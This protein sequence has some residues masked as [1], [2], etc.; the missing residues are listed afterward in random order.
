MAIT[1]SEACNKPWNI[2]E[3]PCVEK[4]LDADGNIVQTKRSGR[5][6]AT[7]HNVALNY[8]QS[9]GSN[10]EQIQQDGNFGSAR[11]VINGNP[12]G[13]TFMVKWA[14]PQGSDRAVLSDVNQGGTTNVW[15]NIFRVYPTYVALHP[16]RA[17][18]GQ[19]PMAIADSEAC[20]KPW[21]IL[22]M[23]CVEKDLDADGNQI[24]TK[25]SGRLSAT[26]HNVALNYNQSYGSNGEQIQQDGDFGSVRIVIN[27]TPNGGTPFMV[28]WADPQGSD[29]AVLSDVN[30]GGTTNVWK[31]VF[32]VFSTYVEAPYST[33]SEID[34]APGKALVTKDWV[35]ANTVASVANPFAGAQSEPKEFD[36]DADEGQT[37]FV[38]ENESYDYAKVYV[39]GT[40]IRKTEYKAYIDGDNTIV[41][42]NKGLK[43]DDWVLIEF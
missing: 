12:N 1:D 27:G 15:Q 21:N 14:P 38:I 24:Q 32:K 7:E 6:S 40:R 36:F 39:N 29:R 4:D 11:I 35:Q 13:T 3:L 17:L 18:I 41:E 31:N 23:P 30:Q 9:Y 8:N 34:N 42:F 43:K 22:E 2:L 25:R 26:E 10:G 19:S 5:L 16:R 20:N 33:N 28:K 37:L